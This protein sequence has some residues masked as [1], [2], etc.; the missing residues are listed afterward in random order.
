MEIIIGTDI[1]IKRG[2]TFPV[3]IKSFVF[4][5]SSLLTLSCPKNRKKII[6][7]FNAETGKPYDLH[8][9]FIFTWIW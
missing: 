4:S 1:D 6:C 2:N 9:T 5:I 7:L 8:F 3:F